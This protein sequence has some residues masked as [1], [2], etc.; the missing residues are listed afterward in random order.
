MSY[1][2][3][4][5]ICRVRDEKCKRMI[6]IY[7]RSERREG[8]DWNSQFW[9]IP[10]WSGSDKF[11]Q[12]PNINW[13]NWERGSIY[14]LFKWRRVESCPERGEMVRWG[15]GLKQVGSTGSHILCICE[16]KRWSRDFALFHCAVCFI[17]FSDLGPA[18]TWWTHCDAQDLMISRCIARS[19]TH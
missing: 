17:V 2:G 16:T 1:Y 3:I 7:R 4:A 11:T 14:N 9:E 6:E 19:W 10:I 15:T 13:F 18:P 5:M 12:F 8:F